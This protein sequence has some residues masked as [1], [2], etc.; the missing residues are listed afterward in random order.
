[1]LLKIPILDPGDLANYRLIHSLPL[2]QKPTKKLLQITY[3]IIYRSMVYLE[4]LSKDLKF[5]VA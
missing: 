2:T 1:M 3:V 4:S 5:I